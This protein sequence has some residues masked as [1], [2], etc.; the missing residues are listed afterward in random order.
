M[1]RSNVKSDKDFDVHTCNAK[2]IDLIKQWQTDKQTVRCTDKKTA[3]R[4]EP[5]KLKSAKYNLN[6][7]KTLP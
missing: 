5:K 2:A 6:E 7:N 4:H 3:R 1:E